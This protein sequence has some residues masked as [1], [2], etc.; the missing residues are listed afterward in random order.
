[1]RLK[2]ESIVLKELLPI[3]L[4]CAIWGKRWGGRMVTVHCDNMGAVAL[5]NSGYSKI[6]QIMHLLR[7]LFF[8]RALYQMELW[9]VHVPGRDNTLA[10][11]LSRNNFFSQVPEAR[12]KQ[13][14]IPPAL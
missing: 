9:A 5:V 8:I 7:C 13:A 10:D 12:D 4:A 14:G 6:Q 3:V 2:E 11:A 1:M